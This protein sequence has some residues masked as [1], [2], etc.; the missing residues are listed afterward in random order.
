MMIIPRT[1][2]PEPLE[3]R[4]PETMTAAELI[5]LTKRLKVCL[6]HK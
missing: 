5:E 6:N 2:S 1:P 4:D 3:D